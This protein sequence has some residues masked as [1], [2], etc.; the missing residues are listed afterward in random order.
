MTARDLL[1]YVQAGIV[2]L[3][4][5]VIDGPT[6]CHEYEQEIASLQMVGSASMDHLKSVMA[7]RSTGVMRSFS[8]TQ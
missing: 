3:I 2:Y 6:P 7:D 4:M 8:R 1:A 5:R